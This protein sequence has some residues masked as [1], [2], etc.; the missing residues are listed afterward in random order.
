MLTPN[1]EKP[2]RKDFRLTTQGGTV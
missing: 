2:A 1:Q